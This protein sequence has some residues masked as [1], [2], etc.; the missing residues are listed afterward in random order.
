MKVII[1]AWMQPMYDAHHFSP[2]VVDGD[3]LR[4]SGM[5]GIRPDLTVPEDL[6]EQFTLAF[7]NLRGLSAR[8]G[9]PSPTSRR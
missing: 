6:T 5:L 7:E 9:S 4:C 3:Q 8:W 1:P 2:A